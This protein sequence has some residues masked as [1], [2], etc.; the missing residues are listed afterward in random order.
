MDPP[1]APG[2]PRSTLSARR[3]RGFFAG[4]CIPDC[5]CVVARNGATTRFFTRS[6][7]CAGRPSLW[8][9]QRRAG[10]EPR[11]PNPANPP[12][13]PCG[14][15]ACPQSGG[16][17]RG[18][19]ARESSTQPGGEPNSGGRPCGWGGDAW[20]VRQARRM[21]CCDHQPWITT[22]SGE[23]VPGRARGETLKDQ[24]PWDVFRCPAPPGR[25]YRW[26]IAR[27]LYVGGSPLATNTHRYA[28]TAAADASGP[29]GFGAP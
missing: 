5:R 4:F 3:R 14:G 10:R 7:P 1:P 23:I 26:P 12:P 19:R 8:C 2:V 16:Q 13:H 11:D 17:A 9:P 24:A 27:R 6:P 18:D 28:V 29:D 20:V 22:G 21:G 15:G 25:T